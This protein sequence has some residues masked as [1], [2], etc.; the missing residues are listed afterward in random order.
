MSLKIQILEEKITK[1]VDGFPTLADYEVREKLLAEVVRSEL[2]NLRSGNAHTKTR[3]EVRG[4]GKKPWKQKGTGRARHGSIRSP[5]W[6]GG[7]VTFGPRNTVNWDRK[8][9]KSAKLA[10]LKSILKDR[11][12]GDSVFIFTNEFDYPKTKVAVDILNTLSTKT[13]NK[14][15]NTLILYTTSEKNNL[16]GFVSSDAK[17]MNAANLKIINIVNSKNL[18][19]TPK[20][21]ELLEAKISKQSE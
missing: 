10:A 21:K 20:A 4:G 3:A 5:L 7:G 9:N 8:I 17:L 16:S 18:V 13:G 6:V 1:S 11:L 2:M 14:D 12:V 19:L 15:K